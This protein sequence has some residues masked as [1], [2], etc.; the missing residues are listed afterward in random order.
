[1]LVYLSLWAFKSPGMISE[2]VD[3]D[4]WNRITGVEEY[5]EQRDKIAHG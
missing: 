1:M 4:F 5:S 3:A 2:V